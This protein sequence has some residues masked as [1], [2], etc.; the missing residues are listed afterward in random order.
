MN[1]DKSWLYLAI[2]TLVVAVIWTGVTVISNSRKST[3]P[4]D[5]EKI[6]VPLN[7]VINREIFD[8]LQ[9]RSK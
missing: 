3:I 8:I 2:L 1:K 6:M 9:E 4:D 5:I 7:P